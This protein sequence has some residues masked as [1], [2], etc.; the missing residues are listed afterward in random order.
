[1]KRPGRINN[2]ILLPK[3]DKSRVLKKEFLSIATF[4]QAG[5]DFRK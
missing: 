3:S 2:L 5:S 4:Y 1:M